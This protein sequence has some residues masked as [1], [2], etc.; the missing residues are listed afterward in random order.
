MMIT[1]PLGRATAARGRRWLEE[2]P[3]TAAA[4]SASREETPA[5][6]RS[7]VADAIAN[8]LCDHYTRRPGILPL[9]QSISAQLAERDLSVDAEKGV[10]IAAGIQEARFFAVRALAPDKPVYVPLGMEARYQTAVDFAESSI[11]SIDPSR[12]L[13]DADGG[14]L[15][16]SDTDPSSGSRYPA[17]VLSRLAEW[18]SASNLTVVADER[19][20]MS[21]SATEALRPIAGLPGM[22]G[23]TLT[24]GSFSSPSMANWSVAWFAGPEDLV[25]TVRSV[26]QAMTI[27]SPAADQYAALASLERNDS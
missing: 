19:N 16:L 14:L 22:E 7:A 26:K 2:T 15:I 10:V 9:C 3:T 6:V 17:N 13:P 25:A 23:R 20:L 18:A 27:C 1:T 5:E 12:S 21:N 8:H 4:Q 24:L 11:T